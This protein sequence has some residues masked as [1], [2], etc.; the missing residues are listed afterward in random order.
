VEGSST[1][2]IGRDEALST[3]LVDNAPDEIKSISTD[4]DDKLSPN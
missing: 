2:K 1:V 4:L 3:E